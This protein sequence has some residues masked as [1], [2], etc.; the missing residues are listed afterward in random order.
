MT[1]I[2]KLDKQYRDDCDKVQDFIS[3]LIETRQRMCETYELKR[4]ELKSIDTM[5]NDMAQ[6]DDIAKFDERR[7]MAK[8]GVDARTD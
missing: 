5:L 8:E 4:K 7:E 3:W 6:E 2:D 1:E